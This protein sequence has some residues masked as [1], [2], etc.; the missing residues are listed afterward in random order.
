MSLQSKVIEKYK[1]TYPHDTLREIAKRTGIQLTR[2]FRL[3]N[4]NAM[5]L[6]EYETFTHIINQKNSIPSHCEFLNLTK[7][8]SKKLSQ[9]QLEGIVRIINRKMIKASLLCAQVSKTN[10]N[11]GH[12]A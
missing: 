1:E 12:S 11:S 10:L 3:F 8:A 5:K 4:G 7:E 6:E 2:V 9:D